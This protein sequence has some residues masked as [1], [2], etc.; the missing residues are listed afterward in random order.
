[1]KRGVFK[2]IAKCTGKHLC[3]SLIFNNNTVLRPA[4]L[5]KI[6]TPTQVFSCEFCEIFKSAFNVGQLRTTAFI[7]TT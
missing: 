5:L 7:L 6:E 3:W 1:M 2:D 4:T